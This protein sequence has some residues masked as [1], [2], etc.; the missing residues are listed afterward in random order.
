[1]RG[2]RFWTDSKAPPSRLVTP[3]RMFSTTTSAC[4][5]SRSRISRPCSLFRFSVM[6]RLLRCRFWKSEPSRRPTSSPASP[7]SGGGSTRITSA[8][9]SASVRTQEGPA[10]AKVRSITLKRASGSGAGAVCGMAVPGVLTGLCMLIVLRCHSG[11]ARRA[12]PG[13][14]R[15]SDVQ[16]HIVVRAIARPGM[17]MLLLPPREFRLALLHERTPS[18]AEILAV[19]ARRADRLD[20]VHVALAFVLQDLLDGDLGGLDR[21]RRVAGDGAGDLHGRVPQFRIGQH[22]IDEADALCLRGVDPHARIHQKPRP[23]GADQRHQVF[24]AVIAI[25]DAEFGGG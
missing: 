4:S 17:T 23:G 16:L 5:A 20:R 19:H 21:E 8:P 12:E 24:E 1:M 14:S 22:A 7:S 9:Q 2:L 10:R 11:A 13:I 25:G 15:F 18:L 6:A 3:G